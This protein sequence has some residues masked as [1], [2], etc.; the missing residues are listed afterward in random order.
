MVDYS[1]MSLETYLSLSTVTNTGSLVPGEWKGPVP[2]PSKKDFESLISDFIGV[3]KEN[4]VSFM[5]CF[6]AWLPSDRLTCLQ[7]H[8]HPWLKTEQNPAAT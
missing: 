2:L 5:E 4:F 6:I 1:N 7:G 8:F 3:D